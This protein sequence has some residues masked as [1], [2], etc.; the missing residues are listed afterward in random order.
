MDEEEKE[1][2]T[3]ILNPGIAKPISVSKEDALNVAQEQEK[4][5]IQ[6]KL[7]EQKINDASLAEIKQVTKEELDEKKVNELNDLMENDYV[8]LENIK[9]SKKTLIILICALIIII[10]IIIF[11]IIIFGNK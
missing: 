7:E 6:D 2:K 5:K 4:N 1:I 11:E 3:I 8:K 10:G 9:H